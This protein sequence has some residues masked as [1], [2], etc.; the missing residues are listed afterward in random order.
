[1][2]Q[3]QP[4]NVPAVNAAAR[5]AILGQSIEMVQQIFSTTIANPGSTNN[6]INIQPRNVGMIKRFIVEITGT[7]QNNG[8]ATPANDATPTQFGLGNVLSQVVFND[9]NNNVRINT[10]G[11]HLNFVNSA[12]RMRPYG[13]ALT[14][15]ITGA[16]NYGS[17]WNVISTPATI[18]GGGGTGDFSMFYDVPLSYTDDDLRG[19]IYANVV[20]ATMNLQLTINAAPVAAVANDY[21]SAVY[22]GTAATGVFTTVTVKVYQVYLDQLPVGKNG[23]I[24]PFLDLS[25]V[26]ELKNTTFTGIVVNQDF[27]MPYSN[28][29]EFLSTFMVFDNGVGSGLGVGA[30]IAAIKLQSANFTDIFNIDPTLAALMGGRNAIG[31]DWP[32][33]TYYFNHRRKPINTIQY[34]NMQLVLNASTVNAN[35]AVLVGYEDF[36]YV[37]TVTG[38][39]SLAGS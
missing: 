33:G 34:G 21:T 24:L 38:A 30:D 7:I 13:D 17:N 2:A 14:G 37:N 11:W 9:L 32:R 29:R 23:P 35:A 36:A 26:Y 18:V 6:V 15:D 5:A 31:D 39:Q 8:A 16:I 10:S 1:M 28:F 20:N 19:A 3:Q 22:K 4:V 27:P 25:T 12:K